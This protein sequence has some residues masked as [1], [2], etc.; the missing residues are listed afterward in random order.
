VPDV[1]I[2]ATRRQLRLTF[3]NQKT[4]APINISGGALRVQGQS[5]DLPEVDIDVAGEIFDGMAGIARWLELGG[6]SFVE[7]ADLGAKDSALFTLRGKLTDLLG[8]VDWTEEF[9]IRWV[10]PPITP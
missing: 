8:K 7:L 4:G 1:V 2:G 9:D 5:Q 10:R 3:R 6:A